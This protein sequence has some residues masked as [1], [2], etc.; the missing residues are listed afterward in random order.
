MGLFSKRTATRGTDAEDA[1]DEG[2]PVLEGEPGVD[3][4]WDRATDGPFDI[5]ERPDAED[6]LDFGAMNLPSV[7]MEL[8]IDVEQDTRRVVGVTCGFGEDKVQMQVFAAPRSSGIWD[9]IRGELLAAIQ[10][11]GG[12]VTEQQGVMGT[13]LFARL[14]SRGSGGETVFQPA[15]FVGVDG[16]KWFLRAVLHGPSASD[17]D[18]A[19]PLLAFV[20][21]V[22]VNRG[23]DPRPPRE[24]LALTP[25]KIVTDGTQAAESAES[26][27]A[28]SETAEP[29]TAGQGVKAGQVDQEAPPAGDDDGKTS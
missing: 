26:E 12:S 10:R 23:D 15:R 4:E 25:P 22:V 21:D 29:E 20:R 27:T 19:R 24:L 6:R 17:D 2:P 16:P 7:P 14:P 28:E 5:S 18:Q 8:R 3:R 1:V 9:D 11:A 13:E